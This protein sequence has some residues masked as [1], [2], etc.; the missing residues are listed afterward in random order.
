MPSE[1]VEI[2]DIAIAELKVRDPELHKALEYVIFCNAS[3]RLDNFSL[4]KFK[5]EAPKRADHLAR[6]RATMRPREFR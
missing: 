5:R 6:I 2:C 4:E 1:T 3:A